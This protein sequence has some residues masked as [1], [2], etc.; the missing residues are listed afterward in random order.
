MVSIRKRV[1][2]K[3]T[4]RQRRGKKQKGG[5]QTRDNSIDKAIQRELQIKDQV[6]GAHDSDFLEAVFINT[7]DN[8][9]IINWILEEAAVAA[10]D[11]AAQT[12][13]SKEIKK[14]ADDNGGKLQPN[15]LDKLQVVASHEECGQGKGQEKKAYGRAKIF[16][17]KIEGEGEKFIVSDSIH[18]DHDV[19][20]V[21]KNQVVKEAKEDAAQAAQEQAAQEQ[22]EKNFKKDILMCYI[23]GK[24]KTTIIHKED[25]DG[26][27]QK[28]FETIGK[29]LNPTLQHWVEVTHK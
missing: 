6:G 14:A 23:A 24:K 20:I 28:N 4:R 19:S 16:F 2:K 29:T 13:M 8:K 10:D 27:E 1:S 21:E 17:L 22:A 9:E 5:N 12:N 26:K 3:S 25:G 18:L 15:V 7:D 11:A